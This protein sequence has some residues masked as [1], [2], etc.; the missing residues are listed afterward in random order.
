MKKLFQNHRF[1]GWL[2]GIATALVV[3]GAVIAWT[4][5]QRTTAMWA[6]VLNQAS[7]HN[8]AS[9]PMPTPAPK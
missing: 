6:Y 1:Q 8:Q 5:H 4:D 2:L 7:A 9:V 3:W